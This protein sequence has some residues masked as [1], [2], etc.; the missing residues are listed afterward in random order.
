MALVS[1]TRRAALVAG[2]LLVAGVAAA[3][4]AYPE[5]PVKILVGFVPGG[6][7]DTVARVLAKELTETLGKPFIVDNRPGAANNI[8]AEAVARAAPDGYTLLLSAVTSAINQTLYKNLKFDF[9]KDFAHIAKVSEGG[10]Y[11]VVP[12]GSPV[13]TPKD[14]AAVFRKEPGR[15]SYGSSGVGSSIHATDEMFM[16]QSEVTGIHVPYRG[17]SLALTAVMASEVDFMFD[18]TALQFIKGG[19]LKALAVTTRQR[20]PLLPNTPTM[21][22]SG[23]PNFESTWWYGISA[24][25][26]TSPAIVAQLN[27]ALMKALA[28]P[29][30]RTLLAQIGDVP[31]PNKPE[32]YAAFV[33]SE[34]VRWRRVLELAKVTAE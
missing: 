14:L 19:K 21:M 27:G 28:K 9:A 5:R 23:Y 2:S 31:Q 10:F 11:L 20:S 33:A 30:V 7:T 12:P 29:E 4:P 8:A 6:G 25:A 26:G 16:T 17:S 13:A 1:I 34:V 32:E 24:P 15:H 18:N 3:Q 22:E